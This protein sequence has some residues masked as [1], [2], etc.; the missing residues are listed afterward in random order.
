MKHGI[1]KRIAAI[2]LC[3]LLFSQSALIA[4]LAD[5][6]PTQATA[7]YICVSDFNE[8]GEPC[9]FAF[10]DAQTETA[11][12]LYVTGGDYTLTE[13]V[14][15]LMLL[16]NDAVLT[17]GPGGDF[18]EFIMSGDSAIYYDGY[19]EGCVL[20]AP[21]CEGETANEVAAFYM[22]G[23]NIAPYVIFVTGNA[24]LDDA[25][26]H[27]CYVLINVAADAHLTI[28]TILDT[29]CAEINGEVFIK[30]PQSGD[31]HG[32]NVIDDLTVGSGGS[33]TADEGQIL[34]LREGAVCN[35][36]TTYLFPDYENEFYHDPDNLETRTFG[37]VIE[38]GFEGFVLQESGENGP[39]LQPGEGRICYDMANDARVMLDGRILNDNEVF[40][41]PEGDSFT[42]DLIPPREFD[43]NIDISYT[44]DFDGDHLFAADENDGEYS[45]TVDR[46]ALDRDCLYLDLWWC[47]ENYDFD[48]IEV[49]EN[50]FGLEINGDGA[51][52]AWLLEGAENIYTYNGRNRMLVGKDRSYLA[53]GVNGEPEMVLM[54]GDTLYPDGDGVLDLSENLFT[55]YHDFINDGREWYHI[56]FLFPR[57]REYRINYDRNGV[58][59]TVECDG[60]YFEPD[61]NEQMWISAD[62]QTFTLS[63]EFL[64]NDAQNRFRGLVINYWDEEG[65]R[66]PIYVP[67]NEITNNAYSLD[68]LSAGF[69][70]EIVT[71]E[72]AFPGE[73][74]V[75]YWDFGGEAYVELEGE[76]L[77]QNEIFELP[78]SNEF[79]M[80]FYPPDR[81]MEDG[82]YLTINDYEY[83]SPAEAESHYNTE[84]GSYYYTYTFQ[85]DDLSGDILDLQISW[86]WDHYEFFSL[87]TQEHE[88]TL[89]CRANGA[90]Q[91]EYAGEPAGFAAFDNH[92]KLI[93]DQD[94]GD[95]CFNVFPFD[96]SADA[97]ESVW[98]NGI[99]LYPDGDGV[100]DPE[101]GVF[102]MENPYQRYGWDWI[103]LD[104]N[105]TGAGGDSDEGYRIFFDESQITVM[106]SDGENYF[107]AQ[108]GFRYG[109]PEENEIFLFFETE[110]EDFRGIIVRYPGEDPIYVGRAVLEQQGYEIDRFPAEVE[111]VTYPRAFPGEYMVYFTNGI[112]SPDGPVTPPYVAVNG[113]PV[114]S[115]QNYP[116]P[117]E[118]T[119]LDF[120]I[121]PSPE[122]EN[123]HVY[124][125][126][127][128]DGE[129][130]IEP[131]FDPALNAYVC[132]VSLS[133]LESHTHAIG[134]EISIDW[135]EAEHLF[136]HISYNGQTEFL[137][138]CSFNGNGS[139]LLVGDYPYRVYGNQANVVLSKDLTGLDFFIDLQDAN[140]E[141]EEV[142]FNGENILDPYGNATFDPETGI[143]HVP[144]AYREGGDDSVYIDFNFSGGYEPDPGPEGVQ[145]RFDYVPYDM[146]V[147]VDDGEN[148]AF[149]PESHTG[150]DFPETSEGVTITITPA[151]YMSDIRGIFLRYP[152]EIV[153]VPWEDFTDNSYTLTDFTRDVIIEIVQDGEIFT[154]EDGL[155]FNTYS[156][157]NVKE[158]GEDRAPYTPYALSDGELVLTLTPPADE[159]DSDVM[160]VVDYRY[161][162]VIH[163]EAIDGVYTFRYV[164]SDDNRT[165]GVEFTIYWS[166]AN[167]DYNVI[168]LSGNDVVLDLMING[169]G[170]VEVENALQTLRYHDQKRAIVADDLTELVF[171]LTLGEDVYLDYF[172]FAN[173][174]FQMSDPGVSYNEETGRLILTLNQPLN[175]WN[176]ISFMFRTPTPLGASVYYDENDFISIT[177]DDGTGAAQA[178]PG[179]VILFEDGV[180][181]LTFR[182]IPQEW[183]DFRGLQI[184]RY[185]PNDSEGFEE[186]M[187]RASELIKDGDAY[188]YVLTDFDL[189][190]ELLPVVGGFM[191]FPGQFY[192]D[193]DALHGAQVFLNGTLIPNW[194]FYDFT[195]GQPLNFTLVCPDGV[196]A[197]YKVL[198]EGMS[199]HEPLDLTE[200]AQDL[201]FS[202]T[203][204]GDDGFFVHVYWT[205]ECEA[206]HTLPGYY[207]SRDLRINAGEHATLS[208]TDPNALE[209]ATYFEWT[210][211][212]TDPEADTLKIHITPD[213]GYSVARVNIDGTRLDL[214]DPANGYD[215][216]TGVFTLDLSI[217]HPN[218]SYIEFEY[219]STL[220]PQILWGDVDGDGTLG[221]ADLTLL[222]KAVAGWDLGAEYH[223][224]AADCD[225]DGILGIGDITI[226]AKAIAGWTVTLGPQA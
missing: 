183:A 134:H 202:Y 213:D 105:F 140:A 44:I 171:T 133:D 75:D 169:D 86:G 95:L 175:N 10:S 57:P 216:G 76:Y 147:L 199:L 203:P 142:V 54:D 52:Y 185:D 222:A 193:Y 19:S 121:Q 168:E 225:G 68:D 157:A 159:P 161:D 7:R 24:M 212:I 208:I 17:I 43:Y 223:A 224:D 155:N 165:L 58:A 187:I 162:N 15:D 79:T 200:D 55:Y 128:Y 3:A 32:L 53:F 56:F 109:H 189:A 6:G 141:L 217:V 27:G 206:Y 26:N 77:S 2:L 119:E 81:Y 31:P 188:V 88:Y 78:D 29:E 112:P 118:E 38:S 196:S 164:P 195:A 145:Y 106:V 181:S 160:V 122:L 120:L 151:P 23:S 163:V 100:Y 49:G 5:G 204:E 148:A 89:V 21:V 214:T 69:S 94:S 74:R 39:S 186:R 1:F 108:D 40:S 153:A 59:P 70:I 205:E 93:L 150:Y 87:R 47:D 192:A 184:F 8:Q 144:F 4:V 113:N 64:N 18:G 166:R 20:D 36:F 211:V 149:S 131:V 90:G 221:I 51:G 125:T 35:G 92:Q 84:D 146:T 73:G 83:S 82:V 9:A 220:A 61:D 226:L 132:S 154:G 41:M 179:D 194:D 178:L 11:M 104:F 34:E 117:T 173:Q 98:M 156:G 80:T 12:A 63:W 210:R 138:H 72:R 65:A 111:A 67:A 46:T 107:A 50:Q 71:Y 22:D 180:E 102:T 130:V 91:V 66:E 33:I 13:D 99:E 42:L 176:T 116:L 114:E 62:A 177:S 25:H 191:P 215:A 143:L 167:M 30:A 14:R 170:T 172:W 45:I 101:N 85:K 209:Q 48:H 152:D 137:L 198:I 190:C 158:N 97:L 201:S 129:H 207:M 110:S 136:R 197:P 219:A 103:D 16:L 182:M 126:V 127:C 139:A 135:T 174:R 37:Y 123:E 218:M 60:E 28:D 96:D 115:Y 124:V